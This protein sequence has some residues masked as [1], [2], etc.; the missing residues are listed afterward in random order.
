M[1]SLSHLPRPFADTL[2]PF[3]PRKVSLFPSQVLVEHPQRASY[4]DGGLPLAVVARRVDLAIIGLSQS[5]VVVLRSGLAYHLRL[6][7]TVFYTPWHD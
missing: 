7:S 6:A 4:P 3:F 5:E 1:C 2:T